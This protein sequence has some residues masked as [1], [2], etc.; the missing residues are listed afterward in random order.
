[1]STSLKRVV[2]PAVEPV[3]LDEFKS[4]VHITHSFQDDTLEGYLKA[5]R[6]A[7]E[8]Y[9]RR[10]LI[11]QEWQMV[12][13][14]YPVGEI[15][16]LRGPV[17]SVESVT[18]TDSE[19]DETVMDLTDFIILTDS[20]PARMLLKSSASWPSATLQEI[21]GIRINYTTGYGDAEDVPAD[22]K[23][24]II[25]FASFADDNRGVEDEFI[26]PSF[27]NLLETDRLYEGI[28]V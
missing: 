4:S 18:V 24:A 11:T 20:S 21:G 28:E 23:H 15:A 9:Q 22:T 1:M 8:D 5:G 12:F 26:P 7:A 6:V 16:L 2:E 10:S 25:I 27:Y 17:Q 14:C 3:S 19:G 13:D